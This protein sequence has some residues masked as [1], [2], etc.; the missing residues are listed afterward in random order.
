MRQLDRGN[1][2]ILQAIF[3]MPLWLF[4]VSDIS[5]DLDVTSD[6]CPPNDTFVSKICDLKPTR[7]QALFMYTIESYASF[8][9][10]VLPVSLFLFLNAE[11]L[12]Q[13]PELKISRGM[14]DEPTCR[15]RCWQ[16]TACCWQSRRTR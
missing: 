13:R 10:Q 16:C 14:V 8:G 3:T 1:V 15:L 11:D 5:H 9:K 6:G 4:L 2:G 7:R 12:G